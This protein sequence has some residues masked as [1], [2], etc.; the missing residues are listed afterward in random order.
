MA[1]PR[2]RARPNGPKPPA[3][4][5]FSSG[6]VP[7]RRA[8]IALARRMWQICVSATAE[9]SAAEGLTPLQGGVLAY[10]NKVDGEPGIDQDGLAARLG[11]D[12]VSAGRLVRTAP[13]GARGCYGSRRAAK[14]CAR[15][16]T[17]RCPP[18]TCASSIPLLHKNASSC[19]ISSYAWSKQTA[20]LPVLARAG[21]NAAIA[22]RCPGKQGHSRPD[23][24]EPSRT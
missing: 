13:T 8:L 12:R 23:E 10:L 7:V 15:G 4:K 24:P 2:Q 17:L 1:G 9:G 6:G 14:R 3:I 19:S 18:P 11:V 22:S 5:T 20:R 16:C 21:A